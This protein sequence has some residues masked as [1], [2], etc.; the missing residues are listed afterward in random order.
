LTAASAYPNSAPSS[1]SHQTNR[2]TML[3]FKRMLND[4]NNKHFSKK[5][6]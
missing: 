3:L 6:W 2:I 1:I 4:Y 5:S